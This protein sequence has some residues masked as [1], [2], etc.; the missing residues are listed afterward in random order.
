MG[1]SPIIATWHCA[2]EDNS[3]KS[4]AERHETLGHLDWWIPTGSITTKTYRTKTDLVNEMNAYLTW[5]PDVFNMIPSSLKPYPSCC[6]N[7]YRLPTGLLFYQARQQS[8]LAHHWAHRTHAVPTKIAPVQY[9]SST[10]QETG[11]INIP[12]PSE[13]QSSYSSLLPI[14]T[15]SNLHWHS[16][17]PMGLMLCQQRLLLMPS[18]K[19]SSEPIGPM[20]YQPW[21]FTVMPSVKHSSEPIGPMLYQPWQFTVMPSVKRSSEPIGPMLY[22]PWQFTVMSSVK[23]SSEPI[24]PTLY[25]TWQFTVMP[26]VMHS[27]EPIGPTLYQTWQFTVM[28]SVMHSSEPIGPTLYQPWRFTVM[29]FVMHS[30]EPIGPTLY[31][32]WQ[33]TVMPSVMHSSEPIWP[34]LYQTWQLTVMPSVMHSSEP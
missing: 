27:S 11:H 9:F 22:Q 21:Q 31:Q 33:F 17:E 10:S 30:S 18:V 1:L 24:G 20:L 26:S 15:S 23:H 3:D 19:H 6:A 16:T 25:Q 2:S 13:M 29:P 8:P 32:T 28:P 12:Q 14:R 5:S 7:K 4:D 34:M